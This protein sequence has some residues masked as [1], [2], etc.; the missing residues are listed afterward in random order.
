MFSLSTNLL[1]L[2]ALF[3]TYVSSKCIYPPF[4]AY[5]TGMCRFTANF[6]QEGLTN[7]AMYDNSNCFIG[8]GKSLVFWGHDRAIKIKS[9]LQDELE[10]PW[11]TG[12]LF[13][14]KLGTMK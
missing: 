3:L 2:T 10:I 5:K 1:I 7:L 9:L 8:E 11:P 13:D 6:T 12:K 4:P 14:L